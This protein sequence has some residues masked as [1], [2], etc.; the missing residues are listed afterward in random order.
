MMA[1]KILLPLM[2]ATSGWVADDMPGSTGNNQKSNNS[3]GFSA[4]PGGARLEDGNFY[5][6][7]HCASWWSTT[8]CGGYL[9]PLSSV[10]VI[11]P[12]AIFRDIY[13]DYCYVNSYCTNP[14][15]GISIRCLKDI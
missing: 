12:G 8:E 9:Q 4:I 15:V 10:R 13:H 14:R 5:E 11:A 7:G 2:A 6:M 1:M 3:V